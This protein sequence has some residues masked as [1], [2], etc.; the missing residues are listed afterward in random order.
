MESGERK[1]VGAGTIIRATPGKTAFV[2]TAAHVADVI[3]GGGGLIRFNEDGEVLALDAHVYALDR[4][5][6]LALLTTKYPWEGK[7]LAAPIATSAPK[8]GDPIWVIGTPGGEEWSISTGVISSDRKCQANIRRG[9]CYRTNAEMYFGS[10]GGGVFNAE[11]ALIGVADYVEVDT[12]YDADGD[13]HQVILPG[14]GGIISW[15]MIGQFLEDN[16]PP[17]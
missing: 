17:N 7:S 13:K 6:D 8:R 14:S 2:L 11:G 10:S 9:M 15:Y 12:I 4:G 5:S 3:S 1:T 16:L